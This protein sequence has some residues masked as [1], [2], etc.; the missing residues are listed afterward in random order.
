MTVFHDM[1][2]SQFF[3]NTA[4]FLEQPGWEIDHRVDVVILRNHQH[5]IIIET[6]HGTMSDISIATPYDFSMAEAKPHQVF[7]DAM[8]RVCTFLRLTYWGVSDFRLVHRENITVTQEMVDW[9]M[10]EWDWQGDWNEESRPP[11]AILPNSVLFA[12]PD[13]A[14]LFVLTFRGVNG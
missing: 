13:M 4:E 6:E 12:N 1:M 14:S 5:K 10:E 3:H 8:L 9:L 7:L 11:F 2:V